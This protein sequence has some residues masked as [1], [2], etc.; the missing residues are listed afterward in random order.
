[1]T[2]PGNWIFYFSDA[3]PGSLEESRALLGGKGAGLKAMSRAGLH[4]PPGFTISTECCARY[5]A[6]GKQFPDGLEKEIRA[7][8]TRLEEETGRPY[9]RGPD[10][11][12]VSV[13]SGAPVSMPGMMDTILNCGLRPG[14]AAELEDAGGFWDLY[15]QFV[16]S[17]AQSVHGIQPDELTAGIP[18]AGTMDRAAAEQLT[19]AYRERCSEDF[20]DDPWEILIRCI[21]AV[22]ESWNSERAIAYRREHNIR[23]LVGTAVNVQV[24]FPSEVSG[25]VFTSDPTNLS[26]HRLVIEASYGLGETV[27]SGDVTPDRFIV[28]RDDLEETGFVPGH[29]DVAAHSLGRPVHLDPAARSLSKDRLVELCRLCLGVEKYFGHPV[30]VEWGLAD[31]RFAVLQARAIRGLDVAADIEP[32]REEEIARLR[33]LAASKR[34]VWV[35]HNL[36][37]TLRFPT[38]FTWDI[39]RRFMSGSGGFGRMYRS[40]GYVPSAAVCREGFLELICGRIYADPE[41]LAD[42]F[43]DGLPLAY[44]TDS[45]VADPKQ[46]DRAPTKFDADRADARFLLRLPANLVA[47]CRAAAALKRERGRARSVFEKDILPRF[48]EYVADA[49]NQDLSGMADEALIAELHDRS[50]KVMDSFG[51]ESLKPGFLGG[52]A[53]DSLQTTLCSLLG[54]HD[55]RNLARSLV[56]AL[57]GD[58]T[59]EQD[60]LLYN[61]AAGDASM[62]DFLGRFGHRCVEELELARPRWREDR[63]YLEQTVQRIRSTHSHNPHEIHATALAKRREAE[64]ELPRL[65]EQAGASCFLENVRKYVDFAQELLPFRESGRHY[66]MMGYELLRHVVEE[67]AGRWE[68]DNDFYFLRMNELDR[69]TTERE[70]LLETIARRRTRWQALRRLDMPLVVDSRDLDGLGLGQAIPAGERIEGTAVASGVTTGTARVV[71]DPRNP[72]NLG[73]EYVLVCSSTDPGWTPLFLNA[74]GLIVERGGVLSHGAIVARD[75][76]IPAVVCPSITGILTSGD[77]V[78][79]DGDDGYVTIID[80]EGDDA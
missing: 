27:V 73:T 4:V 68:L 35:A 31:G 34:R 49:R 80:G 75:F 47:I 71:S 53:F 74:T 3:E 14:L 1:M 21:R 36:D 45:L 63:K 18:R 22:F 19:A 7:N 59:F 11:L 79:V 17:F 77:I 23:D 13:R 32:A 44:D 54:G 6:A 65:L 56:S 48:I 52:L 64:A 43:F 38:P 5:F 24:M 40:L 37:E 41:R 67:L 2:S 28:S 55:G 51:P 39:M 12:L 70:S 69:F 30:D 58:T 72:G 26:A 42:F 10:P 50:K 78:R 16:A 62:D 46:L 8:L 25:I 29:K 66:L 57:D 60:S 9:A 15:G 33:S 20:P 61:V 76:G